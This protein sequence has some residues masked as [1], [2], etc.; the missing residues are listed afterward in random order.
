M[1]TESQIDDDHCR[2]QNDVATDDRDGQPEWHLDQC[3]SRRIGQDYKG[4]DQQE[5]VRNGIQQSPQLAALIEPSRDDAIQQI[6]RPC[7][8][9]NQKGRGHLSIQHQDHKD[10]DQKDTQDRQEVSRC[11]EISTQ[12]LSS[13]EPSIGNCTGRQASRLS[14]GVQHLCNQDGTGQ[15]EVSTRKGIPRTVTGGYCPAGSVQTDP[16]SFLAWRL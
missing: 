9:K 7:Q 14:A 16:D 6:R 15:E 3:L 2:H 5:F 10:G 12:F 1:L 4:A 13:I 11:H 8:K